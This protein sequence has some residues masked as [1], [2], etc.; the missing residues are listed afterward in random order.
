VNLVADCFAGSLGE[1]AGA[2]VD[3][4]LSGAGG[5]ATLLNVH[6][7][8]TAQRDPRL[9]AAVR[10]SWRVFADGAPIAWLLRRRGVTEAQRV[11]GPDLMVEVLR[12]DPDSQLRHFLFGSTPEVLQ[13]LSAR[14]LE[15]FPACR[16]VGTLAPPPGNEH[17]AEGIAAIREVEP[18]VVWT[19]LGAPKQELWAHSWAYDLA[20]SL[21]V[22]VGAAFDF[23]AGTKP[24]APMWMQAHGLEWLHRLATEP[25]RLGWR[26]VRTNTEFLR[27]VLRQAGRKGALP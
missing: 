12:R 1:A 25:R 11:P 2:V 21:V 16:I 3:R 20:P 24:R 18:H 23:N 10:G 27:V 19:A 6:V 8:T 4:A 26:Y 15:S 5:Y 22:C 9:A 14:L 17:D 13:Q 7:L